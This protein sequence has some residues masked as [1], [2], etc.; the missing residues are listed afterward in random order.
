[1]EADRETQRPDEQPVSDQTGPPQ[2]GEDLDELKKENEALKKAYEDLNERHLR[3]AADFENFRKRTNRQTK[4]IREFA[5]EK[6][7]V[8]LLDVADN[9]ERALKAD[10]ASLREGLERIQKQFTGIMERYGI[11]HF[12]CINSEF[13]PEKH[14][15]VACIPSNHPESTI[16]EEFTR[17][18]CMHDRVIRHARVAVSQGK[19]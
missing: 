7:A 11:R 4:E 17:G 16:V 2:P 8:D 15:A 5:L 19:K 12:E 18:Y 10:D 14:E 1:M 9:F 3:L 13:N 6:F